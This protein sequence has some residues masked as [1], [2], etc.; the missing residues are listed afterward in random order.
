MKSK[1]STAQLTGA[2][3]FDFAISISIIAI[4]ASVLLFSLNR[5][6]NQVEGVIMETDLSN[7]RWGLRELWAHR[8]A[9]GQSLTGSEVNNANPLRLLSDQP[10][11][12]KGEYAQAP[13]ARSI[14]YFDTKAKRLVYIFSDGHQVRYRLTSIAKLNRASLGA[15]G[16]IDLVPD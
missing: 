2:S 9:I 6:Q 7:M 8:N 1:I 16:G 4:L 14:W 12:Y 5:A 15:I 10:S 3:R 11:N 13:L